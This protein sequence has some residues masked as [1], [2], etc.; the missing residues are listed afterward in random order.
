MCNNLSSF[1]LDIIKDRLYVEKADGTARRSAQTACWYIL[2]TLTRLMAPILS[3]N[4]ELISDNYQKD[5]TKSIHLQL[6]NGLKDIEQ[7]LTGKSSLK[8]PVKDLSYIRGADV[9]TFKALNKISIGAEQDAQWDMLKQM[10]SVI[11]K[12]IEEQREQGS[13]KHSLEALVT[14]YLDPDAGFMTEFNKFLKQL[15]KTNQSIEDFFKEFLIVSQF[16]LADKKDGLAESTLKGLSV[17][18]AHAQGEKCQR[19]WHQV[20]VAEYKNGLCARCQKILNK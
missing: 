13:I 16:T 10:R 9:G 4:A 15:G 18:V 1:Y 7:W 5:K 3:F 17:G 19:C 8:Q 12:A 2:D 14:I 20:P 6:F 11:L